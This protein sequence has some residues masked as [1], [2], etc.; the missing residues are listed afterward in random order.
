MPA[1]IENLK[2]ALR[3]RL[4]R[5]FNVVP[6]TRDTS[7]K[8]HLEVWESKSGN[9]TV[10]VEFGQTDRINLWITR[11]GMPRDLPETIERHDKDPVGTA[12]SD[13]MG[14][15]ANSNLSAYKQFKTKPITRLGVKSLAD[16]TLVLDHLSR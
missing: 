2:G 3:F 9:R 15:G 11:L 6:S 8:V 7:G 10:G 4:R 13:E 12:W 16:V 14:K 5:D 1:E